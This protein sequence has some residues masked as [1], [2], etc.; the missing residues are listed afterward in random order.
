MGC[1]ESASSTSM[2]PSE[3][4][5]PALPPEDQYSNSR[6]PKRYSAR[7]KVGTQASP[8]FRVFQPMWS[9]CRWVQRTCVTDSGSMPAPARCS[10]KAP[11]LMF[12]CG[13]GRSLSLPTQVSTATR[14]P[15][16]VSTT[17]SCTANFIRPSLSAKLG[18]S[19]ST[20]RATSLVARG[21]I[22]V[23][24][25]IVSISMT[26]VTLQSPT[27]QTFGSPFGQSIIR[28]GRRTLR[29]RGLSSFG[30]K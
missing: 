26:R 7:G 14:R 28:G 5:S 20:D 19:H 27:C 11:V 6:L 15:P 10:R 25:P 16:G 18:T 29:G 3:P 24:P 23:C 9:V 22:Q 21:M 8:T 1:T 17:M 4:P 12:Q 13:S 30:P 2:P